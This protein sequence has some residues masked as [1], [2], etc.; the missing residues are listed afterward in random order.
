MDIN[1]LK[2]ELIKDEKEVL[3]P[4][5]DSEG[6]LTV[7]VG[8]NLDAKGI[9]KAVS[10]LMLDEDILE[11]LAEIG[12][13]LP[14]WSTLDPVRQ[15]VIANMV[16]NL[17]MAKFLK[18]KNTIKLI[19]AGNYLVAADEMLNSKWAMQVGPRADRLS[20]MMRTGEVK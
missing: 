6:F 17:G 16:F 18:F 1:L 8:H 10:A 13:K 14:W 9:S 12:R 7:G 15:R 11:V 4:Y 3:M 5:R 20:S 19:H 2:Q